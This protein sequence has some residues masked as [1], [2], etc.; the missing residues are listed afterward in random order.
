VYSLIPDDIKVAIVHDWLV[1]QAGAEK[2]L[3]SLLKL[4]P[5]AD[6][7]TLIEF[8][9]D[10]QRGLIE[11]RKVKTSFLQKL[12]FAKK[13]YR[14]YLPFM[15]LAIEQFDLSAYQIILSCSSAVAKGVLVGP[16]QLHICYIYSPIRYAWDLQHQY[17]QQTFPNN[18]PGSWIARLILHYLRIWDLR[19]ANS[20]DYFVAIS[21]FIARRVVKTYRRD[22]TVIYPPV[23][24]DAFGLQSEKSDYYVTAQRMVP[25]KRIDIIINAFKLLPNLKLLV[26]GDGPDREKLQRNA[27]ENVTFTGFL[28][29]S[30]LINKLQNAKA[31]IFAAEEDFGITPLEAQACGTPVIAYGKGGS[32]ETIIHGKTG[33]LFE[34]QTETSLLAAIQLFES[35]RGQFDPQVLRANAARFSQQVFNEKMMAFIKEK[36]DAFCVAST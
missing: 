19:T 15:P 6:L 3:E 31:F 5:R 25:Y 32:R 10:H 14:T 35:M 29:E 24:I 8:L 12:P 20:V 18:G 2:V 28:E 33:V 27:G 36:Y 9:P 23:N 11:G 22:S 21:D 16:D 1:T 17:L 13:K 7:Y 26:I 30:V 34:E 4:F